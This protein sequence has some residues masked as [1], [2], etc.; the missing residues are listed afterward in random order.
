MPLPKE[1]PF[2]DAAAFIMIYATSHHALVDRAQLKAGE[3]VLERRLPLARALA[4]LAVP[5]EDWR[6][7][8]RQAYVATLLDFY[9]RRI[10]SSIMRGPLTGSGGQGWPLPAGAEAM[11]TPSVGSV[12]AL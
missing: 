7:P 1:F 5:K 9:A 4:L 2:V 12:G 3:T 6:Q 10:T 11:S 8:P